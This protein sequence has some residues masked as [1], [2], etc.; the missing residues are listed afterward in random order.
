L[1]VALRDAR[2][3]ASVRV[4][5]LA[6]DVIIATTRPENLSVRNVMTGTIARIVGDD[7]D[8]DMV[9]IDIGGPLVLARVTRAASAALNLQQGKQIWAL[10]KAVSIRGHA[11]VRNPPPAGTV[12]TLTY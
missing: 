4:Q 6:R 12:R 1:H 11:F 5:V 8:T 9:H 3:G 2:A 7:A 10:V